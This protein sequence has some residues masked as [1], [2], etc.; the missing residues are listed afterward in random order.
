MGRDYKKFSAKEK[1][2]IKRGAKAFGSK[3]EFIRKLNLD[4]LRERTGGQ[5]KVR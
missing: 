1:D 4:V 5:I 3:W 2:A